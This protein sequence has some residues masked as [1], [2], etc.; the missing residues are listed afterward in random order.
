MGLPVSESDGV[1]DRVSVD[2]VGESERV[3]GLGVRTRLRLS[4]VVAEVER[5]TRGVREPVGVALRLVERDTVEQ[6]P[7][8]D[9]ER[10]EGVGLQVEVWLRVPVGL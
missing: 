10:T 1:A 4:V 3:P 8:G 6:E 9:R 5:E 7:V 2:W